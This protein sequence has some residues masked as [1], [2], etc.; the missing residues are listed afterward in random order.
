M[1]RTL[2]R[3]VGRAVAATSSPT[4]EQARGAAADARRDRAAV[5]DGLRA[6]V[7]RL[8]QEIKD[9][10]DALDGLAAGAGRAAQERRLAALHGDL[11]RAQEELGRYQARV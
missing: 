4:P 5:V 7:R 10:S 3:W 2:R 6:D 8:Q 1:L 9:A 11:E